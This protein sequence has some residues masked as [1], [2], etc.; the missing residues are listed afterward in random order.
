MVRR[1]A[2]HI[3]MSGWFGRDPSVAE[4]QALRVMEVASE[5]L[6][7][8]SGHFEEGT[9]AWARRKN[10]I[11]EEMYN[12]HVFISPQQLPKVLDILENENYHTE[13]GILR[14]CRP[15]DLATNP[16]RCKVRP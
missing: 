2:R 5:T 9:S 14:T 8:S 15:E 7:G 3:D 1:V 4:R 16:K 11:L 13:L 10:T 6:R 12:R